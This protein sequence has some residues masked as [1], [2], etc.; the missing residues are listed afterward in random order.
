MTLPK[1]VTSHHTAWIACRD[2]GCR[3]RPVRYAVDGEHLVCFG[4]GMLTDVEDETPV[5]V[6]VHEIA[7]GALL[8]E[9]GARVHTA[10][11]DEVNPSACASLLDHVS[12]G[13][14][15]EEVERSIERHF[16]SRR[17]VI[18]QTSGQT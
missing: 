2:D 15:P 9:F 18:L 3:P 4:D 8:A 13:R 5:R 1:A 6:A 16:S 7:G 10:T 12:L 17:L 14:S 11:D